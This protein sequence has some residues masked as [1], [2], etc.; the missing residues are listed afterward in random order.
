MNEE[1]KPVDAPAVE[2]P[3]QDAAVQQI[4]DM[5]E[6]FQKIMA[7]RLSMLRAKYNLKKKNIH[8]LNKLA[9]R[10]SRLCPDYLEDIRAEVNSRIGM[11][12]NVEVVQP[13]VVEELKTEEIIAEKV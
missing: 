9:N 10:Y 1:N 5:Y 12:K 6:Q 8:Q 11:K 2:N 13:P 3:A 7:A 4:K